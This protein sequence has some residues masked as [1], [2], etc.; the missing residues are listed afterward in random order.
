MQT[1]T[2]EAIVLPAG[3]G[4]Q[5]WL[6]S[7]LL[8]IKAS[9][10]QTQG[11]FT[12]WEETCPPQAGPPPHRHSREDEMFYIIDGELTFTLF[13]ESFVGGPGTAVYLPIGS[14]HTF[15]NHTDKPTRFLMISTNDSFEQFTAELGYRAENV[16]PPQGPP[17]EAMLGKVMAAC[18]ARGIEVFPEHR[19]T[20]Q[21]PARGADA[22]YW[23]LG[24]HVTFKLTSD[25]TKGNF[26]IFEITSQVGGGV[27]P[28]SHDEMDEMFYILSG[29]Y[30]F[31]IDGQSRLLKA[32]DF[33]MVPAG[34]FHT[35]RNPGPGVAK[36]LDIHTPGGFEAFFL[37]CGVPV[38]AGQPAPVL[39]PP[40]PAAMMS[41]LTK[42]KMQMPPM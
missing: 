17:D 41:L 30:Q 37:D 19:P 6:L 20:K 7:D 5:W 31:F 9:A 32:G 42:H 33:A 38:V 35:F 1:T 28:H 18:K 13:D 27:P 8:T 14:L 2:R 12:V 40:D 16:P 21:M 25:Q 36:M 29:Q 34:M 3:G 10:K 11:R 4:D 23:V 22:A 39:A 24:E 26:S 15:H